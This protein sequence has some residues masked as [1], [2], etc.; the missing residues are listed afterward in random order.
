MDPTPVLSPHPSPTSSWLWSQPG[1]PHHRKGETWSLC[2][3]YLSTII[4]RGTVGPTGTCRTGG[5]LHTTLAGET[6]LA[7]EGKDRAHE[8]A[9]ETGPST[10]HVGGSS[11]GLYLL[12]LQ[13][14][15]GHQRLQEHPER[16]GGT[17][18]EQNPPGSSQLENILVHLGA[19]PWG[20]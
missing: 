14:G 19:S 12:L 7:L 1:I 9:P 13:R 17:D 4:A 20:L 8:V 2:C 15:R 3:P 6:S 10:G 5:P 18:S 16:E 11:K